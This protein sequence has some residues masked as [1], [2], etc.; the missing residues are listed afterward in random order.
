M[1]GLRDGISGGGGGA[2]YTTGTFS[3]NM[4]LGDAAGD[5]ITVTGTATFAENITANGGLTL[6]AGDDLIG[7]A[8]SDITMNTDKFTVAGAT[9]NTVIAGSCT[10]AGLI[11]A[12]GGVTLGAGDDLIGSATSDI[13]INTNKF[14]VA[15]ASGDTLIAGTLE[16]T[17]AITQTATSTVGTTS[18]I[19]FRDTG[20]FIN[21]SV[22]GQLDIVADTTVAVSG[23]CTMDSTL[24]VTGA[25]TNTIGVQCAAV[26]RTA[27]ADGT[28]TGLIADGTTMVAVVDASNADFWL[29]LPTPTPGNI[30]WLLTS[31]DATGFE[32]RSDTPA[33]VA[34][35]GGSG[36][37][38]EVAISATAMM[39]RFVCV[40]ATA[41]IGTWWDAD[42]DEAKTDAA[43]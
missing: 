30:V 3:G 15:G 2:D 5:T 43:A 17:G 36:A 23:A 9:G 31:A 8:T 7:S 18:K 20:L 14:T 19:Q 39:V 10:V 12:N 4:T 41:W 33:S 21:S 38:A 6:G 29:T 25:Q 13:T 35:N 42:G 1:A 32:V 28:G 11:I 40:S 26:S 27:T 16:V 37:G 34:I 22:D 24:A